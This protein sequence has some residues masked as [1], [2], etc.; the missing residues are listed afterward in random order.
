[1][2]IAILFGAAHGLGRACRELLE[3]DYTAVVMGDLDPIDA[4]HALRCDSANRDD[5]AAVFAR[6]EAL[7]PVTAV[8]TTVGNF[9]RSEIL[10]ID[11]AAWDFSFKGNVLSVYEVY[12]AAAHYRTKHNPKDGSLMR[13]CGIS[14]VNAFQAHPGNAHYAAMKAAV[15]SLTRSFAADQSRNGLFYNA[16]A[17]GGI[18][19]E[20][21]AHLGWMAE[22][23]GKH[24]LGRAASPLDIANLAHFLVSERN[25]Y[26]T[27][28]V[29]MATG[30]AYYRS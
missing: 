28:E 23:E 13:V 12:R 26:M 19:H 4:P 17:P 10:E 20:R 14:S 29:L 9:P 1:M 21:T 7:G 11:H 24:P 2:S 30:G 16:V 22:F 8:V 18:K 15:N 27:G 5:V 3:A 6:A 25:S